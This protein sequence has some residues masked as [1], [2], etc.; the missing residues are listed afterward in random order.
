MLHVSLFWSYGSLNVED[1][2]FL[3]QQI[4]QWQKQYLVLKVRIKESLPLISMN[5]LKNRMGFKVKKCARSFMP[6]LN[7]FLSS[8]F[9]CLCTESRRSFSISLHNL[10]R[11]C[12]SK[13][14][15]FKKT[16]IIYMKWNTL[17]FTGHV[18][19]YPGPIEKWEILKTSVPSPL[20]KSAGTI[21]SKIARK[22]KPFHMLY[23]VLNC[24][25][26]GF[27]HTYNI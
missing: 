3:R 20:E 5:R 16:P 8:S 13:Q 25:T 22:S 19:R 4:L 21:Y 7:G 26:L 10:S 9:K 14:T 27:F 18:T 11:R 24:K 23:I 6:T 17:I 1:R 12:C 15:S 2:P